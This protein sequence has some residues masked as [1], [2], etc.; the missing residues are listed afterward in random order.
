LISVA[1]RA[2]LRVLKRAAL[3]LTVHDFMSGKGRN[4]ELINAN[5]EDGC[6]SLAPA[7]KA[8]VEGSEQLFAVGQ[9]DTTA[10]LFCQLRNLLFTE[11]ERYSNN[12]HPDVFRLVEKFNY[13]ARTGREWAVFSS[14]ALLNRVMELCQEAESLACQLEPKFPPIVERLKHIKVELWREKAGPS[15]PN[16]L[17]LQGAATVEDGAMTDKSSSSAGSTNR[18]RFAA[19]TNAHIRSAKK[20]LKIAQDLAGGR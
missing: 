11:A 10:A 2:N 15:S 6:F 8:L 1:G 18:I 7:N 19:T 16:S 4:G 13:I 20:L 9:I 5:P 12:V 3:R 17:M 14:P